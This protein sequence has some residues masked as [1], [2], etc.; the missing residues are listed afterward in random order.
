MEPEII[1]GYT[2]HPAASLFSCLPS[3][4]ELQDLADDIK[5][6][7]LIHPIIIDEQKQIVDG[8][9][10]AA[11][12]ELAGIKPTFKELNGRDPRAYIVS[13]NLARR[14]LTKGQQAM[15]LAMI[16]PEPE[17]GRGKKDEGKK[18]Q[19]S[20][21][22]SR[23]RVRQA[24]S[25]LRHSPGLAEDVMKGT[26]SLDEALAEMNGFPRAGAK[27]DATPL[28]ALLRL[29]PCPGWWN[30]I[31]RDYRTRCTFF[32]GPIWLTARWWR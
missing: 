11:A 29:P 19:E 12:C 22:F 6:H 18:V 28:P 25:I 23:E 27:R 31:R 10:R 20:C 32:C 17:R 2:V 15:V 7:G 5:E 14:N 16:Y 4:D 30:S 21:G 13:A 9:N 1:G 26:I 8:R 3:P 24:R